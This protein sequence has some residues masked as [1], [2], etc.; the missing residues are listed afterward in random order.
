LLKGRRVDPEAG[1]LGVGG[2]RMS[3][4]RDERDNSKKRSQEL[5]PPVRWL[6]GP[7]SVGAVGEPHRNSRAGSRREARD[8]V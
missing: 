5:H 8:G 1:W 7:T 6:H 3:D 4:Q 2:G